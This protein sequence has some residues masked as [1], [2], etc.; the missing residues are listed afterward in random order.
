MSESGLARYQIME[1]LGGG[2]QGQT[3]R[4]IDRQ[5]GDA[6]AIKVLHLGSL[7]GDWKPFD[8]FERECRALQSLQHAGIPRYL[9]RFASEQSGDFFLVMEL[10]EGAPLSEQLGTPLR[11]DKLLDWLRQTLEI[12]SYLHGLTPP[13]IHRDIKP[14]NLMLRP[15]GRICLIDFGGVR[16]ALRPEGG[17][18][19]IGTFGYMAPEQLHG[20][21]SPATDIYA[22]GMT[23]LSLATGLPAEQLPRKGLQIDIDALLPKGSLREILRA[24][25]EPDPSARPSDAPAVAQLQDNAATSRR[26]NSRKSPQAT[27]T[28]SE[29]ALHEPDYSSLRELPAFVRFVLWIIAWAATSVVLAVE[30]VGVPA[31]YA[32]RGSSR[33]YRKARRR[34]RLKAREAETLGEVHGVRQ[35]LQM[36]ATQVDPW[37][38]QKSLT[39]GSKPDR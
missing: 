3:F 16:L 27:P 22:L 2:S 28:S 18:T 29:V 39:D 24:M 4:A 12:L 13:V 35:R 14:S 34:R 10:I 23:I 31:A 19:M 6:V 15:D 38:D 17:S 26:S 37:R 8:L 11:P 30:F 9:D 20:E 25:V 5:R 36:I 1:P 33:R 21:A 32:I 7:G